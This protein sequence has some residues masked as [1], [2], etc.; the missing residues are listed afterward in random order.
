MSTTPTYDLLIRGGTVIDGTKAPRFDADVAVKDGRIAAVGDL[1][2]ASAARTLDAAGL[3]VAPGFIDSHTHDDQ[4][5]LAQPDMDFK[6]SQGVTTVI[7]GNCGISAAPLVRGMKL[8]MPL[9]LVDG[10]D[11]ERHQTFASW[12][13]ALT[14]QPAA[15][16][17]AAL[18]G[19]STLR[20]ATMA[21]LDREASAGE[22][23]AMQ[24]LLVE[25]LDAGAIGL[26]TGTFYPPALKATTQEII[27]V[28][29]PLTARGGLYVTHMRDESSK[30][31]EALDETFPH[32][33]R[34]GDRGGG[35]A[36]Q[37]AEQ[38]QLGPLDGDAALHPRGDAAAERLPR[39]LSLH[40]RLDHDPHRSRHARRPGADR[41]ER[42]A[43]RVRRPR[44]TRARSARRD[45]VS[46]ES[47]VARRMRC[48][49]TAIYFLMDEN[50][51][52]QARI[53]RPSTKP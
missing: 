24:A 31:M 40:R 18:V 34:T 33:P 13:A 12:V 19:H 7:A 28:G 53:H 9:D 23:A 36:P 3:I 46:P 6:V 52:V 17:V 45:G 14:A 35:V 44:A 32:R 15:T 1:A 22:I 30:V 49:R 4:A 50:G 11:G 41:L 25:A 29:R 8:P 43:S 38:A 21:D 51:R 42:A 27:E 37:G 10:P 39:L 47:E 20:A 16:N 5:L 2:G 48:R 26:S